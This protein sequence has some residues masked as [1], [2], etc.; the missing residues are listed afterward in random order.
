MKTKRSLAKYD[1][2]KPIKLLQFKSPRFDIIFYSALA[3]VL[4]C[5][6]IYLLFIHEGKFK[7]DFVLWR[8]LVAI[9]LVMLVYWIRELLE[10]LRIYPRKLMTKHIWTMKELMEMTGKD[11]EKTEKIMNHVLESCFIVD[12]SCIKK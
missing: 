6:V 7:I 3:S 4:M 12:K 1:Y 2:S 10:E 8:V 9:P 11:E 5:A